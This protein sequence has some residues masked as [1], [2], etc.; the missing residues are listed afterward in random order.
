MSDH[1]KAFLDYPQW[2]KHI[3]KPSIIPN[4]EVNLYIY[5][6]NS[7]SISLVNISFS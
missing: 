7:T 3:Q 1:I 5:I 2:P 6:Y 4:Q